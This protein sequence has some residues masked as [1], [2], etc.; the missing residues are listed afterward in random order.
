MVT[1]ESP[2]APVCYQSIVVL[3]CTFEEATGSADWK[4]IKKNSH[5]DLNN[6]S[7]VKLDSNCATQKYDSCVEV[8]L[9]NVTSI[10]AG[11]YKGFTMTSFS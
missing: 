4:L 6:G 3:K 11:K 8:T 10:W 7:F 1:I 5:S 9:K 2:R